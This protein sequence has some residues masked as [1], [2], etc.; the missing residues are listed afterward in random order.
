MP[1]FPAFC[2]GVLLFSGKTQF[3]PALFHE[4]FY[5]PMMGQTVDQPAQQQPVKQQGQKFKVIF[6]DEPEIAVPGQVA[7]L[8]IEFLPVLIGDMGDHDLYD[9]G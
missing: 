4:R 5:L 1:A 3:F 6:P 9:P 8:G 7:F 2:T